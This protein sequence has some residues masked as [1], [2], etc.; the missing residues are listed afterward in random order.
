MKKKEILFITFGNTVKSIEKIV[1]DN[2]PYPITVKPNN[3]DLRDELENFIKNNRPEAVIYDGIFRDFSNNLKEF[4][5]ELLLYISRYDVACDIYSF[6]DKLDLRGTT[7][8]D[9]EG[10]KKLVEEP[11]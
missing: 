7:L 10:L 2:L 8:L 4:H 6:Q 5:E 9:I 11:M 1:E 3:W